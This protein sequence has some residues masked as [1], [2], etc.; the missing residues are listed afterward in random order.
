MFLRTQLTLKNKIMKCFNCDKEF[1]KP[2]SG[3][4]LAVCWLL[5]LFFIPGW[6]AYLIFKPQYICPACGM[7]IVETKLNKQDRGR[8]LMTKIS[9]GGATAII[10]LIIFLALVFMGMSG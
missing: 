10:I 2:E 1:E 4:S 5:F 9:G 6:I 7:K 3:R 8:G